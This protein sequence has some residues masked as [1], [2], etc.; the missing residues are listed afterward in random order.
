MKIY[1]NFKAG[2]S[3]SIWKI[4]I[5]AAIICAVSTNTIQKVSA[6]S[7][8]LPSVYRST[9]ELSS[10]GNY[11]YDGRKHSKSLTIVRNQV[12]DGIPKLGGPFEEF[13]EFV[14]NPFYAVLGGIIAVY[15]G[16]QC[17]YVVEAGEVGIA[18]TFGNLERYDPGLHIR[19]PL[20]TSV[21]PLSTKTELMEQSNFV[22]TKE[23]LTVELDTAVLVKLDPERAVELYR[24]V[25]PNFMQKL[26]APETSSSVRGLTSESEAKA[27]YTAG[28]SELQNGM[29]DELKEKLEVKGIMVEDVLLKNVVLPDA[30]TKSIQEK[31]RAEQD[32]ARMEFV[33][34]KESQEAK[35]KAIE[36]EGIAEFQHIVSKGITPSFLQ[37]KGIEATEKLAKSENAKVVIV[38]NSKDSL[39]VILG[40]DK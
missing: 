36:A 17:F 1:K 25:G 4:A 32:S 40:S 22:P 34:Q 30:L 14:E 2:C 9:R 8:M 31:A 38:G 27:L 7:P 39:P 24:S 20:I 3:L 15:L 18:S 35:R 26:V 29:K 28:R 33:L 37:W 5:V 12:N 11:Q 16:I 23:G 21:T 19:N 13:A 10:L 6:F